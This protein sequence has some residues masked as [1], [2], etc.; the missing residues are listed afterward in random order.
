MNINKA[1]AEWKRTKS[2]SLANDICQAL[3]EMLED[4]DSEVIN[5]AP[6]EPEVAYITFEND[7]NEILLLKVDRQRNY[8]RLGVLEQRY[9]ES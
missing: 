9:G 6:A 5:H 8:Q 1:L 4:E 3:V 2:L 7:N